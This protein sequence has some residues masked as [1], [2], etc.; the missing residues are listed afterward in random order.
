[1]LKIIKI[2]DMKKIILFLIVGVLFTSCVDVKVDVD[3]DSKI[4]VSVLKQAE[5]NDSTTFIV[6]SEDADYYIDNGN[7][8]YYY[9]KTA[10]NN[11]AGLTVIALFGILGVLFGIFGLL[12]AFD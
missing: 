6:V 9:D 5:Q 8:I 2:R 11:Q 4:P 3:E 1:M 10:V 7:V 12:G